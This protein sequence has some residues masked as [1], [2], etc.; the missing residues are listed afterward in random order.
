MSALHFQLNDSPSI[1]NAM[2]GQPEA[3]P[4]SDKDG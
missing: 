2:E 1:E 3:N 4:H